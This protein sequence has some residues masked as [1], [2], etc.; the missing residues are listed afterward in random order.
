MTDRSWIDEWAE[1][2]N[3]QV[4]SGT[5]SLADFFANFTKATNDALAKY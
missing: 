1:P 2:L 4:R 5:M 3:S